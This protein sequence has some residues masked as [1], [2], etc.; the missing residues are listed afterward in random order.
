MFDVKTVF[1]LGAGSSKEA[2]L[3]TGIELAPQ[4]SKLLDIRFEDGGR[5]VGT[6]DQIIEQSLR[7][8]AQRQGR[9]A[10]ELFRKC[11]QIGA[12]IGY[13]T[14]IDNYINLHAD[15][16]DIAL[17]GK[18]AIVRAIL[19]AEHGSY[20]F[21]GDASRTQ[22][23]Q[24]R[25]SESWFIRF[26]RGLSSEIPKSK[27]GE[28]FNN[29]AIINFNYDRCVEHF[30]FGAVRTLYSLDAAETAKVIATLQIIHP[31]GTVGELPWQN[32]NGV[33][34]GDVERTDLEN[35]S[36]RIRTFAEQVAE[37][38]TIDKIR[39]ELLSG[40]KHVFLGF[41]YYR[42]NM[43]LLTTGKQL[44]TR[45]FGTVLDTSSSDGEVISDKICT[46]FSLDRNSENMRP[47]LEDLRCKAFFDAYSRSLVSI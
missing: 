11:R 13:T 31:Y 24:D 12:G 15:D 41:A 40:R 23:N 20:L 32:P 35:L 29:V 45:V 25:I 28:L 17:C 7:T 8:I 43:E 47:R 5:R 1:I 10:N 42:Q 4:I 3:P 33:A 9:N 39:L 34:F 18:I 21:D 14:S 6:G 22:Y 26:I 37:K 30:L 44:A 19:Q 16:P 38:E 36:A 46:A 2:N 27:I